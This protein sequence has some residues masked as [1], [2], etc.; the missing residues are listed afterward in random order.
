MAVVL[1]GRRREPLATV[2]QE[3]R[4]SGGHALALPT[5]LTDAAARQLLV[6]RVRDELGPLHLLVHNAALLSSGPLSAQPLATVEA[7]IAT[8]L[9]VPIALTQLCLPDLVAQQGQVVLVGS[10]TSFVPLPY[11]ALYSATKAGLHSF[12]NALRHELKPLGVH[13]L[14]AYP[15]T[16]ATPMIA[17]MRARARQQPGGRFFQ[18]ARPEAVGER[19]VQALI[20]GKAACHWG[21]GEALLRLAYRVAPQWVD[22]LLYGQRRRLAAMLGATVPSAAVP[23]ANGDGDDLR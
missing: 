23:M 9:T 18:P 6:E 21:G 12:G 4:A 19:I 5:D 11:L 2:V 8:N 10:T 7:T 20:A 14:I 15:P 1:V 22:R 3:V 17:A 16:T 13:L